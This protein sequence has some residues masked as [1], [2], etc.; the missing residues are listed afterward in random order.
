MGG[1]LMPAPRRWPPR[2]I[3]ALA[4]SG[5]VL[6]L[7]LMAYRHA[8]AML[9]FRQAGRKTGSPETLSLWKKIKTLLLGINIPKPLNYETPADW[10]LPFE[11]HQIKVTELIRLEAWYVPH[12]QTKGLII[13]F[14][15]YAAAKDSLLPEARALHNLGYALLLVDFRGSGGS[16]GYQ[17]SIGIFEADDV[18]KAFDYARS[19]AAQR[20]FILYGRSMGAAAVLRAICVHHLR[21]DAIIIEAVFDKLL[22]TVKNRFAAMGLPAVP[23]A[24]LLLFW[25]SVQNGYFGFDHNPLDYAACVQC[26]AL[27]L[28]G[29]DDP[30]ATLAEG[31]AVFHQLRSPKQF[32]VFA[33]VGHAPYLAAYPEQWQ[34]TVAG[35]L[36]QI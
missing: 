14:H 4:L 3:A 30:R 9:N 7:N 2:L 24:Q 5:A 13:M 22:S 26:P 20:P 31:T 11:V 15:G 21:P 8:R 19:L 29:T 12:P 18:A 10:G 28:H 6:L 17:T 25:G 32:E 1:S 35:F 33:G 27:V 23:A 16:S 34:R 36:V